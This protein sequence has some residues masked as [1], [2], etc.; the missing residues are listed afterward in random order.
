MKICITCK[1]EKEYSE[2][3]KRKKEKDGYNSQCKECKRSY[4]KDYRLNNSDKIKSYNKSSYKKNRSKRLEKVK[5]YYLK[6]KESISQY[7]KNYYQNNKFIWSQHRQ[8]NLEKITEYMKDY[9]S[10]EENI[11]RRKHLR[12]KEYRSKYKKDPIFTLKLTIRNRIKQA[13]KKGYK[14]SSATHLLGCSIEE[15][16]KYLEGKFTEKMN[17]DNYGEYWEIDHIK[18]CDSFN[19]ELIEEQEKCFN[20]LNTQPLPVLENRKKS[21]K[22]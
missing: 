17:W 22:F 15:Y 5:E 21:N 18:P 10:K 3:S 16:K 12:E 1:K 20:Y 7:N 19:L 2:F 14:K 4:E 9:N 8:N 6:N 11:L 13:L